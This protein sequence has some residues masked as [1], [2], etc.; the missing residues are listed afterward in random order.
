MVI[1]DDGITDENLVNAL[2][3][4]RIKENVEQNIIPE[5]YPYQVHMPPDYRTQLY[6]SFAEYPPQYGEAISEPISPS[7][8][9]WSSARQALLICREL[10]RTERRYSSS[11]RTLIT[12]G[13][14]TPPPSQ[15]LSYLPS[16]IEASDALLKLM[17][18]NP[19]VKGVSEAFLSCS[20][21]LRKSFTSWCSVVGHFFDSEDDQKGKCNS[22]DLLDLKLIEARSRMQGLT[23]EDVLPIV[24]SE[25]N[26][27]R[28]NSKA[29]PS[30]RDLAILPT[31]RIVRYVL[32]YK[33][34]LHIF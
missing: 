21:A 17:E 11:L 13:T 1:T 7:D 22:Q 14:C 12:N 26:K 30:V 32:L 29:R 27:I 33:G 19:S 24:V 6:D 9:S 8:L 5:E 2:E 4:M 10:V 18:E 15:M 3:D 20:E 16:L 25:P 28:K 23:S 34:L 31:Q